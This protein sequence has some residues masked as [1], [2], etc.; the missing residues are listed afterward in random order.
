[1]PARPGPAIAGSTSWAAATGASWVSSAP[2]PSGPGLTGAAPADG[3]DART[4]GGGPG[5]LW[6]G[7]LGAV[8][9]AEI[10]AGAVAAG[11]MLVGVVPEGTVPVG[12]VMIGAVPMGDAFG[13]FPVGPVPVGDASA[14][15]PVG[16]AP[17]WGVPVGGA[18]AWGVPVGAA[19]GTPGAP[20]GMDARGTAGEAAAAVTAHE[21]QGDRMDPG[22]GRTRLTGAG[23]ASRTGRG[24]V[25]TVVGE[26]ADAAWTGTGCAA[27]T[28]TGTTTGGGGTGGRVTVVGALETR[29]LV[30]GAGDAITCW[31]AAGGG[32]GVCG[33]GA[34]GGS[35][36]TG[37]TRTWE[38]TARSD[39]TT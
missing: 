3:E 32:G 20:V 30:A 14:P 13:L 7:A 31:P 2:A 17:A 24:R 15:V 36:M 12:V 38:G 27:P 39:R 25:V 16:A 8:A 11:E 18:P 5:A 21:G 37:A 34:E 28:T 33:A 35:E 29:V 6:G 19:V 9:R 23:W 22:R 1:M 26:D 10:P 4:T